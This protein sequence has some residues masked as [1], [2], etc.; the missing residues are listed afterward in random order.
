MI[1]YLQ[2][3]VYLNLSVCIAQNS[4]Y[5]SGS[6]SANL[7]M[8][9]SIETGSGMLDFGDILV[10]PGGSTE[11]INPL[12]GKEFIVKGEAHR[13]VTVVFNDVELTNNLWLTNNNSKSGSL[14]F[15]PNVI[16]ENSNVIRSG[17]NVSLN[18]NGLIGE[19]KFNVGGT[20]DIRAN[21]PIGDYEGIFIISVSY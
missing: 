20:I 16:Q 11:I 6:A 12:S 5:Q 3:L 2:I 9:L 10:L 14:T 1:K 13:N 19:L 15:I 18:P 17:E 21:Q 7:V 4:G 8:P